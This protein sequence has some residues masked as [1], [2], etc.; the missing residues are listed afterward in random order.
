MDDAFGRSDIYPQLLVSNTYA[1]GSYTYMH[2]YGSYTYVAA[3]HVF[4][5]R[6]GFLVGSQAY[7][8]AR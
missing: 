2:T 8:A 1:N 5:N 4:P 6:S 3:R 7:G